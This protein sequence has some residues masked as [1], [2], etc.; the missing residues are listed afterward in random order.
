M[1]FNGSRILELKKC[2][3]NFRVI[4]FYSNIYKKVLHTLGRL[5]LITLYIL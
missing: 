2:H 1:N 3:I 5:V 4:N